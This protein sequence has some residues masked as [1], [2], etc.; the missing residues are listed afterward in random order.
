MS[1]SPDAPV[2]SPP[3]AG[4]VHVTGTE[5]FVAITT[6]ATVTTVGNVVQW[7]DMVVELKDTMSDP[8]VSGKGTCFC[9][10]DKYPG[11]A[12]Q[13]GQ[14]RL[15]NEGG[16]WEGTFAGMIYS[17]GIIE[18]ASA[19]L[20]GAGGYAGLSYYFHFNGSNGTYQMDGLIFPGSPPTP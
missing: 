20:V 10:L 3:A 19:W 6:P 2:A 17:G 1:S 9:N 5:E 16:T 14:Y 15:E 11:G 12:V 7:R 8:R 13:F 18:D 4:A